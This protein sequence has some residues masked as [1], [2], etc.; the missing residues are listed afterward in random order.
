MSIQA[1]AASVKQPYF[2]HIDGLRAIAVLSVILFH[3]EITLFSG[4]FIGVDVFFVISG[5]LITAHIRT[6][7]TQGYFSFGWFYAKRARRLL[8]AMLV[9]FLAT[10]G[11]AWF[12]LPAPN[13]ERLGLEALFALFSVSNFL[14]WNE[15]GYFDTA[16]TLKPLLH[17]WSLSVEEQFYIFWPI[18]LCFIRRE[19][20]VF[21]TLL[22]LGCISLIG[23]QWLVAKQPELV[24][25]MMPFRIVE[26]SIGGMLVWLE[27]RHQ[28]SYRWREW[29]VAV[30]L[31]AIIAPIFLYNE[32]TTFP[33]LMAV[34][35]CVGTALVIAF[36]A[37]S[38][39]AAPLRWA[40]VAYVGLISYSL[41]LN[42][43]P[44]I[45]LYKYLSN[46]F[47]VVD[48]LLLLVVSIVLAVLMYHFVE[49]PFRRKRVK[50]ASGKSFA[51]L[52]GTA[53]ILVV[54]ASAFVIV[55]NGMPERF[56]RPQLLES[57]IEAGKKNRFQLISDDCRERGWSAC[58]EPVE[59]VERNVLVIG[60]SH[61]VDGYNILRIAYPEQHYINISL[62]GCPPTVNDTLSKIWEGW[63]KLEECDQLNKERLDPDFLKNFSTVVIA[64]YW[65]RYQPQH[66]Q[67]TLE[68]IERVADVKVVVFG[69]FFALSKPM[70]DLYNQNIDPRVTPQ[71]VKSFALFEEDLAKLAENRYIFVSKKSLLCGDE[72]IVSCQL[73]FSGAPFSYDDHHMS[74]EATFHAAKV[75]HDEH[76]NWAD[77]INR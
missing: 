47:A 75:L 12:I 6:A 55:N 41:Y 21:L 17:T 34:I 23:A 74:Y 59:N 35:P 20:A 10:I 18:L 60:D 38:I 5:Y 76:P 43:W 28:K 67:E 30:G 9:T 57:D 32:K 63:S 77:F 51:T 33:G 65:G 40:P 53:A 16:S 68:Y 4:G 39:L 56:D 31:I 61:T 2:P 11:V 36:G 48:K 70:P 64:L 44:L 73:E 72:S 25:Y 13:F 46:H 62:G 58:N 7:V 1:M 66:L 3:L 54:T 45:V 50:W 69:N 49:T 15:S 71:V 26:F 22:G 52:A 14:F 24:F 27:Q 19:S 42:H 29:L 37:K 8:P